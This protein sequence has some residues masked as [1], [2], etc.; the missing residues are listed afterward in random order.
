M[1]VSLS[2]SL[3]PIIRAYIVDQDVYIYMTLSLTLESAVF[4]TVALC[5]PET[6]RNLEEIYRLPDLN[7]EEMGLKFLGG[8]GLIIVRG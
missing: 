4:R 6:T 5:S 8:Y 2:I 7:C 3:S 1:C